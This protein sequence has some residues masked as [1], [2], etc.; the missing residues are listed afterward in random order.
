[1]MKANP[2]KFQVMFLSARVNST[3][4]DITFKDTKITG[5]T[6]PNNPINATMRIKS[7]L[8]KESRLAIYNAFILS[9]LNNC[10]NIWFFAN[11]SGLTV[12]DNANERAIRMIYDDKKTPYDMLLKQKL[13]T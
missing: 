11:K 13:V 8:D 7:N 1:M 12:L 3:D 6:S 5:T 10:N 2:E 4:V 9:N